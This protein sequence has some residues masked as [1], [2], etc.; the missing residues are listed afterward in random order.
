MG[1]L[2]DRRWQLVLAAVVVAVVTFYAGYATGKHDRV[3]TEDA[4]CFSGPGQIG[5]TLHDGWDIAVPLDVP[6]TDAAGSRHE[7]GRPD[8]LPPH[9]RG[10]E[11]PAGI[12]WVPVE[13]N[14]VGWRQVI[15]VTC[16]R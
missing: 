8:C 4:R 7:G 3:V 10:T 16:Y 9:G 11:P 15:S 2:E 6:W 12:S 1:R 14:G 5:C 13:V